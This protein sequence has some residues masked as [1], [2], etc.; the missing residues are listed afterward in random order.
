MT[1]A[2]DDN[3]SGKNVRVDGID[4]NS[5]YNNGHDDNNKSS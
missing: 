3:R 1:I 2:R 5:D 4:D